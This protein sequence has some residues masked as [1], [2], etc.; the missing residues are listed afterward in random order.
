MVITSLTKQ[1]PITEVVKHN[2]LDYSYSEVMLLGILK[3]YSHTYDVV[4]G[5]VKE[6]AQKRS[7]GV[8]LTEVSLRING[9]SNS[10]PN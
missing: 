9:D 8:P 2:V 10:I 1:V 7:F 6:Q 4:V 3:K 5:P